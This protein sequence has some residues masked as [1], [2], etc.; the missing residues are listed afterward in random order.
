MKR[1]TVLTLATCGFL[2]WS[3]RSAQATTIGFDEVPG[4]LTFAGAS[5]LRE[6][7][8]GVHFNG[9]NGSTGGV[10]LDQALLGFSAESGPNILGFVDFPIGPAGP[11]TSPELVTFDVPVGYVSIWV[12]MLGTGIVW[13]G[14]FSLQGGGLTDALG[15]GIGCGSS[16]PRCYIPGVWNVMEIRAPTSTIG[17]VT[18]RGRSTFDGDVAYAFDTLTY[19]ATPEPVTLFLL[20]TGLAVGAMTARRRMKR[21]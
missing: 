17:S 12:R 7:Y 15:F 14:E 11:F 2:I 5:P 9:F 16:G 13:G 19:Q 10:I 18:I 4:A 20:G 21:S 8:P 6:F 1:L 3:V